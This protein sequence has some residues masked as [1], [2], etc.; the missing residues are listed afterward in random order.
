MVEV[1]D[2][3]KILEPDLSKIRQEVCPE[4]EFVRRKYIPLSDLIGSRFND[5]RI[6]LRSD[7]GKEMDVDVS[8]VNVGVKTAAVMSLGRQPDITFALLQCSEP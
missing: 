2:W 8:G 6:R 4:N 1:R 3:L 7:M 5:E